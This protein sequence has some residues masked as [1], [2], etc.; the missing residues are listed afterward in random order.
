MNHERDFN[1][2]WNLENRKC[3]YFLSLYLLC[4]SVKQNFNE[5][6]K[7]CYFV[8][9]NN[10]FELP[11]EIRQRDRSLTFLKKCSHLYWIHIYYFNAVKINIKDRLFIGNKS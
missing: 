11:H 6:I 10:F 1:R 7:E 3:I 2:H 8:A 4:M 5:F 9:K